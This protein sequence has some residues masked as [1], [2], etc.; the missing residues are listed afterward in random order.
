VIYC[1][2]QEIIGLHIIY[3]CG[4]LKLLWGSIVGFSVQLHLVHDGVPPCCSHAVIAFPVD[5]SVMVVYRMTDLQT[6]RVLFCLWHHVKDLVYQ[7][8]V[9][10]QDALLNC[11]L[12]TAEVIQAACL[13][14]R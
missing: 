9:E 2:L 7:Q 3:I 1:C 8:K 14:H 11:I 6:L 10:T 13:V 12:D 5:G 4:H